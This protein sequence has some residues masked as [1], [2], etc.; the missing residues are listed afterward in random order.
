MQFAGYWAIVADYS[1]DGVRGMVAFDN[2]TAT[3]CRMHLLGHKGFITRGLLPS[4]SGLVFSEYNVE[5]VTATMRASNIALHRVAES[6][7]FVR[8][9][10]LRRYYGDEDAALYGLLREDYPDGFQQA[11]EAGS[12]RPGAHA[13]LRGPV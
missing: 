6:I 9:G 8:E 2:I 5:L 13:G 11:P 1:D 7:G 12:A 10:V 4:A 3:D